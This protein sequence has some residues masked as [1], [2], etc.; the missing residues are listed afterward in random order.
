MAP[1]ILPWQRAWR[2]WYR[3][4]RGDMGEILRTHAHTLSTYYMRSIAVEGNTI[5]QYYFHDTGLL[6]LSIYQTTTEC[7]KTYALILGR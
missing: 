2:R 5:A 7:A 6:I 4:Q 1:T 3:H